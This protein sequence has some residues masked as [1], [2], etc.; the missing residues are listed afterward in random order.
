MGSLFLG[1]VPGAIQ[2]SHEHEPDSTS[3]EG[4]TLAARDELLTQL[5]AGRGAH[6]RAR[7]QR[8][9]SMP[10]SASGRRPARYT[11][12]V[13]EPEPVAA[14]AATTSARQLSRSASLAMDGGPASARSLA[15]QEL[16][17]AVISPTMGQEAPPDHQEQHPT[18]SLSVPRTL[19]SQPLDPR[20]LLFS[21]PPPGV[22]IQCQVVRDRS[23]IG[24]RLNPQFYVY[25]TE[26][27][28]F[29]LCARRRR[30]KKAS[31]Y[32]VS[33]EKDDLRHPTAFL[34]RV[35]ANALG[36]QFTVVDRG[37]EP[38]EVGRPEA[39]GQ[40]IRQE[41]AAV[42][43][44]RPAPPPRPAPRAPDGPARAGRAAD[45]AGGGPGPRSMTCAI[46]VVEHGSRRV[47]RPAS[48]EDGIISRM[49]Q[50]NTDGLM[51][52]RTL[53]PKWNQQIKAYCLDFQGRVTTPSVKNFQLVES[54][55]AELAAPPVLLQ[56]G[57]VG[58]E[59]FTMDFTAP[60]SLVQAFGI[61]LSSFDEK[62]LDLK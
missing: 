26:G 10:Q 28:L 9:G 55:T 53:E 11:E 5:R 60:L 33:V 36:T 6:M 43:Y 41:L 35:L 49:R 30:E 34:A 48:A 32:H 58:K 44:V 40:E 31:I 3:Q 38:E 62:L 29:A 21:P 22:K 45:G 16:D 8:S 13:E 39:A 59:E 4:I 37:C 12:D 15:E 54:S 61:C 17:S 47:I 57:K 25:L 20:S 51:I 19:P 46:P 56:F 52:L 1:H 7:L 14:P 50:R 18:S 23:G 42:I 27:R 24:N 2:D